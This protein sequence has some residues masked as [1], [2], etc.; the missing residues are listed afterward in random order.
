[1]SPKSAR[2]Y[3]DDVDFVGYLQP[4]DIIVNGVRSRAIKMDVDSNLNNQAKNR[5]ELTE[6]EIITKTTS[7]ESIFLNNK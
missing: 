4:A 2:Y 3:I 6:K 5:F 7:L 1:M